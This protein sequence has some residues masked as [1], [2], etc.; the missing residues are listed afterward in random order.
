MVVV[1]TNDRGG[2]LISICQS[3]VH[4]LQT[5]L[6]TM[7]LP[8]MIPAPIRRDHNKVQKPS[9]AEM[10]KQSVGKAEMGCK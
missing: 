10:S 1:A 8:K 4:N 7:V 2:F 3:F 9:A 5:R 6:H